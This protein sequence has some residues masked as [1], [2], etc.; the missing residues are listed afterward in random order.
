MIMLLL[1]DISVT[2][3]S[4]I[5]MR[6]RISILLS[7]SLT[8]L[9]H[10]NLYEFT[11][12][13]SYEQNGFSHNLRITMLGDGG[14]IADPEIEGSELF[15]YCGSGTV[16]DQ[17]APGLWV[18]IG[19]LSMELGHW[20]FFSWPLGTYTQDS[21][22]PPILLPPDLESGS[23][24]AVFSGTDITEDW[25]GQLL[26][27]SGTVSFAG[28]G[29]GFP[30]QVDVEAWSISLVPSHGVGLGVILRGSRLNRRQR[31]RWPKQ[32]DVLQPKSAP[33]WGGPNAN[34]AHHPRP[35]LAKVVEPTR[36]Q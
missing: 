20:P 7:I 31:T 19:D 34:L 32:L 15:S 9:A 29:Q 24:T 3:E 26:E 5:S 4:T 13:L 36:I 14:L 16:E 17:F 1:N 30:L 8:A 11:T 12:N 23:M 21:T 2:M 33:A 25:D 6:A 10:A 27:G 28:H 35:N 22:V 18:D